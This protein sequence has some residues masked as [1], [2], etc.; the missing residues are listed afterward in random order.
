MVHK[1]NTDFHGHFSSEL[2]ALG[3]VVTDTGMMLWQLV[4]F[5]EHK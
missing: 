4:S 2:P 5:L 1:R 3:S